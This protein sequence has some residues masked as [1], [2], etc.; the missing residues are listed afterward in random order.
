VRSPD[1]FAR[2]LFPTRK[3]VLRVLLPGF[4]VRACS[5]RIGE[6]KTRYRLCG[7]NAFDR[8]DDLITDR[9]EAVVVRKLRGTG[10]KPDDQIHPR[11]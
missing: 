8:V 1:V 5:L 2:H 3:S 11:A 9:F 7:S 4:G 10:C 6:A